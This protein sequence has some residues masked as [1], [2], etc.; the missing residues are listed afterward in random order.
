MGPK[1]GM[2]PSA[3]GVQQNMF[4]TRFED[5]SK[6]IIAEFRDLVQLIREKMMVE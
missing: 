2:L 4:V 3:A 6:R 5:F 1:I